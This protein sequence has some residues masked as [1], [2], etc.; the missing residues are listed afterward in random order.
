MQAL[1]RTGE[2][3]EIGPVD[4]GS[5][6]AARCEVSLRG[7]EHGLL[8]EVSGSLDASCMPALSA[9][10]DQ[11]QCSPCEEAILDVTNVSV[12]DHVG[13]NAIAGLAH[14]V[15]ARGGRFVIRCSPGAIRGLLISTG[16]GPNLVDAAS[17][18]PMEARVA[19]VGA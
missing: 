13:L 8:L 3:P 1:K 10:L 2:K 9:Q 4:L 16:L 12:V 6:P 18:T 7:T 17:L 14:Y 15:A 5:V 19:S 11:L